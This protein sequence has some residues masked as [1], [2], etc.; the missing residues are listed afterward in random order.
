PRKRWNQ[1]TEPPAN[2]G[3]FI[4]RNHALLALGADLPAAVLATQLGLS[5][6]TSS[7]WAQ[8]AQR[9][10]TAYLHSHDTEHLT[11]RPTSW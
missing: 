5:S 3:R 11:C 6:T 8:L 1:L 4:S 2:P 10:Y 9:D 7:Q